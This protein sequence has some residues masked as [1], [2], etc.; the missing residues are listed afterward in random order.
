[1]PRPSMADVDVDVDVGVG[2]TKQIEKI[3]KQLLRRPVHAC[4][5]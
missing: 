4:P 2:R 3:W 5:E 1:M